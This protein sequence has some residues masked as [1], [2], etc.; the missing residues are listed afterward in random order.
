[1]YENIK[2]IELNTL[3]YGN[4]RI[5]ATQILWYGGL[6]TSLQVGDPRN[7]NIAKQFC[8]EIWQQKRNTFNTDWYSTFNKLQKIESL[9]SITINY[10]N[11]K[12]LTIEP[13]KPFW[14]NYYTESRN[15]FVIKASTIYNNNEEVCTISIKKHFSL[16]WAKMALKSF[17]YCFVT[18]GIVNSIKAVFWHVF[19]H[20]K[21]VFRSH[22]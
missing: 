2:N 18:F 20:L 14:W 5:P 17:W 6:C 11:G 16:L 21:L 10:K 12:S 13:P 15:P 22:Y 7:T 4:I 3:K 8:L 9:F 19:D 1:M